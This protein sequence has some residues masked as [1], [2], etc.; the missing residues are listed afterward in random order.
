MSH[1]VQD[2]CKN[3]EAYVDYG[4]GIDIE[5]YFATNPAKDNEDEAKAPFKWSIRKKR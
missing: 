3:G 2:E 5:G 4:H 1:E